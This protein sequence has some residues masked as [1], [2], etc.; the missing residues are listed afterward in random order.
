MAR[1]VALVRIGLAVALVTWAPAAFDPAQA[2]AL[3]GAAVPYVWLVAGV[4]LMLGVAARASAIA[5]AFLMAFGLSPLPNS[6]QIWMFIAT[7]LGLVALSGRPAAIAL[8]RRA[9]GAETRAAV[10]ASQALCLLVTVVWLGVAA[11]TSAILWAG[12]VLHPAA[13]AGVVAS[14]F[15]AGALWPPVSRPWAF[16]A[17]GLLLAAGPAVSAVGALPGA[18]GAALVW[19]GV[20]FI[21]EP[22]RSRLVVWDDRCSLCRPRVALLRRLDWLRVH[23]FEG[24]SDP[25]ALRDIGLTLDEVNRELRLRDGPVVHGGFDALRR[26]LTVLPVSFL[27]A[28]ALSI[29]PLRAAGVRAY[30]YVAQRW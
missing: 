14:L 6:P 22:E 25:R 18:L 19:S 24:A 21:D 27:W 16:V 12:G 13:V 1:R 20:L 17:S 29:P 5:L 28:P 10:L 8:R 15:I 3:A 4:G 30:R 23:R 11:A 2:P 7:A 26:V 9:P